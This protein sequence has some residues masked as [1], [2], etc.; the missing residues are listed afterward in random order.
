ML[1]RATGSLPKLALKLRVTSFLCSDPQRRV[2]QQS[3]KAENFINHGFPMV[4]KKRMG[5][6]NRGL[7][8]I[9]LRRSEN[10]RYDTWG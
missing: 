5:E 8:V 10:T 6:I 9:K 2:R 4:K 1:K 7:E 3:Q